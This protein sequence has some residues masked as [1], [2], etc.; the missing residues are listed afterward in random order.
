M[1]AEL[2]PPVAGLVK[3]PDLSEYFSVSRL[4]TFLTC[5]LKFFFHYVEGIRK[6]TSPNLHLGK[7]VHEGLQYFH[8]AKWRNGDTSKE[9]VLEYYND[10][11]VEMQ[12]N[13]PVTFKTA[14]D[15]AKSLAT[16]ERVLTAYL[17][18]D[19]AKDLKTPVGVETRLEV[20]NDLLPMKLLGFVD[21]VKEGNIPVDFKTSAATPNLVNQTWAHELQIVAYQ[22]MIEEA[23]GE[24]PDGAELVWLVKTKTPKVVPL[25]LPKASQ[26]QKDR[27]YY[28]ANQY[29]I[30]IARK[31]Y[32]PSVGPSCDWCSFRQE[33]SQWKGGEQ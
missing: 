16:G 18:S 17:D 32:Y 21:L 3:E 24:T 9:A 30:G 14:E 2:S 22:I 5:R 28:L 23:T 27:F 13:D 7:V 19:Y 20:N 12:I 4:K 25:T 6:P 15:E 31:N 1:I 8:K 26:I 29:A 10:Q 33:C 11:F